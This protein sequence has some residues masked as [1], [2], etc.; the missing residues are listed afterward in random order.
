MNRAG[1]LAPSWP[2]GS[3]AVAEE[4]PSSA[5]PNRLPNV[6]FV[7]LK[8]LVVDPGEFLNPLELIAKGA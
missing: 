3:A 1:F 4:T 5:V 6:S 2:S 8:Q 7:Q